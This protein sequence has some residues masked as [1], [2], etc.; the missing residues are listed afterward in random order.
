MTLRVISYGGGIQSTALCILAAQG[1]LDD[2]MGGPI[3]AALFANVGDDS[4]HPKTLS[5]V[6]DF[7]IP[8][9]AEQKFDIIE[10]HR[11]DKDGNRRTLWNDLVDDDN[12]SVVIPVRM[13]GGM[14]GNRRCTRDYKVRVVG[15]WLRQNGASFK[16]PARIAIG[17][18]TDEFERAN[19]KTEVGYE[20][21]IFPLLEL[22][23]SRTN[24]AELIVETG[25]PLPPKS[26]CF[27]CP[28]KKLAHWQEMRRDEPE[29][30]D[31]AQE[32]EDKLNVKR[33][34]LGKD[35][36]YLAIGGQRLSDVAAEAQLSLFDDGQ[37]D[38]GYCWT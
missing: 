34:S 5:F 21:K 15:K 31:K 19:N 9:S 23:M 10:L 4:E 33:D 27:F 13:D 1:K 12:S 6:R 35:R 8:W 7:M 24:C 11:T 2:I 17:I 37:C 30:F 22:G 3:D 28:F 26:S 20:K 14:P 38:D 18:S 29:L 16:D 32:L 36:V 25:F